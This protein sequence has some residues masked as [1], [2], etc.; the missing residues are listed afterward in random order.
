MGETR[1]ALNELL[2]GGSGGRTKG[3][4]GNQ[5]DNSA[6]NAGAAYAFSTSTIASCPL[7]FRVMMKPNILSPADQ[8][9]VQV[10][11]DLQVNPCVQ[12]PKIKLISVKS[13]DPGQWVVSRRRP[14][15]HPASQLRHR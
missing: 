6:Q 10:T 1:E 12:N 9:L 13:S 11:A 7:T 4:N 15:G 14:M 5:N 2:R 3:V 8:W